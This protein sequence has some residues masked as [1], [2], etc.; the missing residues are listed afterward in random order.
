MDFFVACAW[1]LVGQPGRVTV[2]G[3]TFC[4][5]AHA[6]SL[7]TVSLHQALHCKHR[8]PSTTCNPQRKYLCQVCCTS[9]GNCT[10]SQTTSKTGQI[11]LES[12]I[13]LLNFLQFKLLH[14]LQAIWFRSMML[15]G[16]GRNND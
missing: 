14:L 8:I 2:N 13:R 6:V 11:S 12:A 1:Y 7:L 5:H 10:V 16:Q 4:L 9:L 15:L 3:I